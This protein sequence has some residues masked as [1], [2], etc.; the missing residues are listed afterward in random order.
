MEGR[1]PSSVHTSASE[2]HRVTLAEHAVESEANFSALRRRSPHPWSLTPRH[3]LPFSDT[4]RP[5]PQ[6]PRRRTASVIR[7]RRGPLGLAGPSARANDPVPGGE[8]AERAGGRECEER[9]FRQSSLLRY[10]GSR[11]PLDI[12]VTKQIP[13]GPRVVTA[14][15]R[16]RGR[17]WRPRFRLIS[18]AVP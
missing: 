8:T 1:D 9:V 16:R 3:N 13:A 2:T 14:T 11:P 15:G 6:Q 7:G 10:V 18:D 5:M 4:G 17:Y 12:D